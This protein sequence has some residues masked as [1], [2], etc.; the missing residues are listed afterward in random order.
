VTVLAVL[1][2][3]WTVTEEDL[4]SLFGRFG[5]LHRVKLC[6][7]P[8]TGRSRGFGFVAFDRWG[9]VDLARVIRETHGLALHGRS[10]V[11]E[12]AARQGEKRG[13]AR[14]EGDA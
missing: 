9:G 1:N 14:A 5:P 7:E 11:V 6:T 8:G 4:R 12:L 13:G 2:L 10:L 3:A